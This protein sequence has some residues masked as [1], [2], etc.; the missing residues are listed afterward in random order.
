MTVNMKCFVRYCSSCHAN[1]LVQL[2]TQIE[3]LKLKVRAVN[4]S[5]ASGHVNIVS[6]AFQLKFI[7]GIGRIMVS[8]IK[9]LPLV[10]S[11]RV[12]WTHFWAKLY[13]IWEEKRRLSTHNLHTAI[14]SRHIGTHFPSLMSIKT[15]KVPLQR[16]RLSLV[17]PQI[18][19]HIS[20]HKMHSSIC[21]FIELMSIELSYI[22]GTRL[23]TSCV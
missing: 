17:W 1:K 12:E 11:S 8:L 3:P 16:R 2:E 13:L 5:L 18:L 9:S 7:L 6:L 4:T 23:D 15:C 22:P 10:Q 14:T 20:M 19:F 21:S